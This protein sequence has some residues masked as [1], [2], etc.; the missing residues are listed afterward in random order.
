M[1]VYIGVG[2]T[3]A[4]EVPFLVLKHTLLEHNPEHELIIESIGDTHEFQNLSSRLDL[5]YGTVFSLQRFLVPK[6]AARHKADVCMHLDSDMLCYKSL[7]PIFN[8]AIEF[9]DKIILPS[10]NPNYKQPQ[11]TAVFA[12][13]VQKWSIELFELSLFDFLEKKTS[14]VELMRL[15][16]SKENVV[17]CSHIFNSREYLD[18]ETVIL[19]LTDLWRQPWVSRFNS[20]RHVWYKALYQAMC[21]NIEIQEKLIE[22][23]NKKYYLPSLAIMVDQKVSFQ[24][25]RDTMFLPP[26]FDAYAQQKFGQIYR[27]KGISSLVKLGVALWV[28][29]VAVWHDITKYRAI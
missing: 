6:I 17:F 13:T 27:K 28:H 18:A 22:G 16:F 12:C 20:L 1:K 4:Q 29:S 19:H 11:Q 2:S 15:H 10:P 25:L 5:S 9:E 7:Q 23:L 3:K 26:Q 21:E 14:Y 24:F 8:Q